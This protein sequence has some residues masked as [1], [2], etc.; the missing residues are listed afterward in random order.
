LVDDPHV[1]GLAVWTGDRRGR[2]EA[3]E[4]R[5]PLHNPHGGENG[6]RIA[7]LDAGGKTEGQH[8]ESPGFE[9]AQPFGLLAVERI[10]PP[11]LLLHIGVRGFIRNLKLARNLA[12]T[13]TGDP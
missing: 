4:F 9:V 2:I 1:Q 10:Q 7:R 8:I 5:A 6:P 3:E 12:V 13:G 11:E